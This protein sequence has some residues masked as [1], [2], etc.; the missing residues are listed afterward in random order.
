MVTAL[1]L[2]FGIA[3]SLT[4]FLGMATI[5]L[6]TPIKGWEDDKVPKSCLALKKIVWVTIT[7][8]WF[9]VIGML[10]IEVLFIFG[11]I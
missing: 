6:S 7:A 4:A 8:Y 10:I 3:L 5:L 1:L 11:I 9:V 2:W